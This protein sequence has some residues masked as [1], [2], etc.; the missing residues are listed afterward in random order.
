MLMMATLRWSF[1]RCSVGS[2]EIE[3]YHRRGAKF[4]EGPGR[5]L[6]TNGTHNEHFLVVFDN[7][8]LLHGR[9]ILK[10]W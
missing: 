3:A 7:Y 1:T 9:Y 5:I 10:L 2:K 6:A 8:D 4:A